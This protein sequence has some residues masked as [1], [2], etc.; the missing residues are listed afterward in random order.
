VWIAAQQGAAIKAEGAA[1]FGLQMILAGRSRKLAIISGEIV[2][3]GDQYK[4]S[5]V[6]AIK[7]SMVV[8]EDATKSLAMTPDVSKKMPARVPV[9]KKRVVLPAADV[10]PKAMGSDQ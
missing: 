8:M 5:K 9:R 7:T 6:V 4:G 1:E 3:V 10:S 2:K